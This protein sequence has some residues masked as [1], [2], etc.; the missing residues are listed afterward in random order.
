MD[1]VFFFD[2]I[3]GFVMAVAVVIAALVAGRERALHSALWILGLTVLSLRALLSLA[4]GVG[5]ALGTD[6]DYV[7]LLGAA[8]LVLLI[9][10]AVL[11]PRW[12]GFVLMATAIVQPG[13]LFL[14]E[15]QAGEGPGPWIPS[16][17]MLVFYGIPAIIAG[18]LLIASTLR[19]GR[20]DGA[21]GPA[22]MVIEE[23]R[24]SGS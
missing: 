7:V 1:Q 2:V 6:H 18:A 15:Q 8:A 19:W 24:V 10:A 21:E 13:I 23:S 11:R 9:P 16:G 17:V 22:P 14:A 12:A 3:L 4:T 20:G 5:M